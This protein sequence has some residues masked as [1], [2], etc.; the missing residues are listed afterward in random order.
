MTV[1]IA[2]LVTALADLP[3]GVRGAFIGVGLLAT[4]VQWR[5]DRREVSR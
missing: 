1:E 4:F 5:Q 2:E 3:W